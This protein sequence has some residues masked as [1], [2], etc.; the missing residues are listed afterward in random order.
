MAPATIKCAPVCP[1]HALLPRSL[2]CRHIFQYQRSDSSKT[3]AHST[4]AHSKADSKTT[5]SVTD[6]GSCSKADSPCPSPITS[7]APEVSS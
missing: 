7:V 3:R 4:G 6:P 1:Q 2:E 5:S